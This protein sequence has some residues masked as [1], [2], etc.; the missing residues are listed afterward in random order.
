MIL[1]NNITLSY[2]N[3]KNII[4]NANFN[5]KERDFIFIS[6]SSGS[7]KSTLLKSF[8]GDLPIK[9]GVLFVNKVD[10]SKKNN[11]KLLALRKNLGIVFQDY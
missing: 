3:K 2:D 11:K 10:L 1:A 9:S 5:I 8:Y 6:G 7:G 4:E